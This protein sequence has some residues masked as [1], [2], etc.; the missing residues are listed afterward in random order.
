ML[1]QSARTKSGNRDV[2]AWLFTA[3]LR[4]IG[5][6]ARLVCSLQ[7]LQFTFLDEGRRQKF[8]PSAD[9]EEEETQEDT[10]VEMFREKSHISVSS[11]EDSPAQTS[12]PTIRAAP[13]FPNSTRKVH[14]YKTPTEYVRETQTYSPKHPFFWTEA[15]DIPSQ[16][17]ITIDPLVGRTVNQASKIVPPGSVPSSE[18]GA[19]G[20]NV[21]SY[22]VGFDSAGFARDVT[23][24]YTK[25]FHSKTW[26]LRVESRGGERWWTRVINFLDRMEP[27]V[28]PKPTFSLISRACSSEV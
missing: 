2:G 5:I 21:L 11:T 7:P 6:E 16:K 17:W 19:M 24:R 15:W 26:K 4:S 1:V 12:R 23:R 18:S 28:S 14:V 9:D 22:V 13:R 3:V 25:A 10:N 27:L 20:D 8:Y